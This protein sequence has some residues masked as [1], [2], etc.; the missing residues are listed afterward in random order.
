MAENGGDAQK[1][2]CYTTLLNDLKLIASIRLTVA[3]GFSQIRLALH[4][5]ILDCSILN[6]SFDSLLDTQTLSSTLNSIFV[7]HNQL[8]G[9]K[10]SLLGYVQ[11]ETIRQREVAKDMKWIV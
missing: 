7:R 11:P 2:K 10:C 9:S 8:D 4:R 6:L 3:S 5:T 1:K